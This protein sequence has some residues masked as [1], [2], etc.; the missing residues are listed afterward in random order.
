MSGRRKLPQIPGQSHSGSGSDRVTTPQRVPDSPRETI[1]DG[2]GSTDSSS[3]ST[4]SEGAGESSREPEGR[5]QNSSPATSLIR[6]SSA[7][8]WREKFSSNHWG[9]EDLK[10]A[11]RDL[12]NTRDQLLALHSL[13][14]FALQIFY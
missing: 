10:T 1:V 14:S 5:S 7:D 12:H 11:L 9:D 2:S 13:V 4:S 8:G 6:G 3:T